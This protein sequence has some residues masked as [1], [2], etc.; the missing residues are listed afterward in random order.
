M[1]A[2]GSMHITENFGDLLDSRFRKIYTKKYQ[3]NIESSMISKLYS[4]D[5][6]DKNYEMSSAVGALTDLQEFDGQVAY[7]N[8]SQLYDQTTYFPEYVLG[9]KVQRKLF[10][11][12]LFAIMDKRPWQMAVSTAR[13]REKM[14]ATPWNNS[15]V[16]AGSDGVAMCDTAHPYSP[17]DAT[18]QSNKGTSALSATAIEATRRLAHTDIFNDRGELASVNYD[19][20]LCTVA[21]EEIAYEIINSRGKVDTADNNRNF[22]YGRYN[23]AVWDRLTN[24]NYWWMIDSELCKMNMIWWDRVKPE[25]NY[26]RDFDT[27]VA[28]WSVY[29]RCNTEFNGWHHVYGHAATS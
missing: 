6:S 8:M 25:Y 1:G 12:D 20:I 11:D 3:E 13:T 23:L 9:M 15:F 10:D 21:K 26:D 22:H 2:R 19:T 4:M 28:K 7:D 16:T 18:T 17:D 14:G 27:Y 5:S 29:M 24:S